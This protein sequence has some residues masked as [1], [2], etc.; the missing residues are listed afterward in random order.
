MK[1]YNDPYGDFRAWGCVFQLKCVGIGTASHDSAASV[2]SY[3]SLQPWAST[4]KIQVAN[5][6][7]IVGIKTKHLN[8]SAMHHSSS[9]RFLLPQP[10]GGQKNSST[11]TTHLKRKASPVRRVDQNYSDFKGT[12]RVEKF[13]S[14]RCAQLCAAKVKKFLCSLSFFENRPIFAD[15]NI[16]VGSQGWLFFVL[17]LVLCVR[18]S[19]SVPSNMSEGEFLLHDGVTHTTPRRTSLAIGHFRAMQRVTSAHERIYGTTPYNT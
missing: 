9:A 1:C 11:L 15:L 8:D 10:W 3:P 19:I 2:Q 5:F 14:F 6:T 18:V 4:W 7:H 12:T 13:C 17:S 16:D